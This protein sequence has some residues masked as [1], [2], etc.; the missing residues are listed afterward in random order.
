MNDTLNVEALL[1]LWFA[2]TRENPAAVAERS[3]WWFGPDEARD[4]QLAEHW[5]P[6]CERAEAGELEALRESAPGCLALILLTD[7][8]PRNL[9][10]GTARAFATDGRALDLCLT[11]HEAG[12]D[13]QL[14]L[15]ERM[16]FWMPLQHAE[17]LE[18]QEL[19]VQ[20]FSTLAA[21]DP[22]HD[23][24]WTE[25]A[26]FA[27]QHRDI[28]MQFGRFPHRNAVLGREPTTEETAWLAGGGA[29]F[30]Q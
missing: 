9:Y 15:A 24:I 26:D 10:R 4:R 23:A 7:Q 27:I 19:S 14:S 17:D 18:L 20:L 12:L 25:P 30:G 21:E 8:L 13:R 6:W 28:I 11:G 29:S 5:L 22:A 16:F 2:D 1:A 3:A